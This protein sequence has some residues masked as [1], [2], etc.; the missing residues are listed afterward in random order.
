VC[1]SEYLLGL[2]ERLQ[3]SNPPLHLLTWFHWLEGARS[4]FPDFS[5]ADDVLV[6][7]VV[8]VVADA[9]ANVAVAAVVSVVGRIADD[10][11]AVVV[12]EDL[13]VYHP[14]VPVPRERVG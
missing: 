10:L 3:Q 12:D 8:V 7:D 11:P 9:V 1:D 5:D 6:L 4:H 14:T 13:A 2:Y